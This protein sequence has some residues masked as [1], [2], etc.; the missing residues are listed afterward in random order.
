MV[1]KWKGKT[2]KDYDIKSFGEVMDTVEEIWTAREH[3]EDVL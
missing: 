1:E 3:G 2:Y